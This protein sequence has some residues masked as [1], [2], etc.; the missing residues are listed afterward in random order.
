MRLIDLQRTF[1]D[2]R[3]A[4]DADE[5]DWREFLDAKGNQGKLAWS[6]LHTRPVSIVL[7]EAGIGK[8][9]EFKLEAARLRRNG[10]HA[11]LIPLNQLVGIESWVLA[12]GEYA[13]DFEKWRTGTDTGHFLFDAVDEARLTGPGALVK[14]LQVARHQLRGAP[15]RARILLSSRITDWAF[16]EVRSAVGD[17]L[18][19]PVEAALLAAQRAIAPADLSSSKD[20]PEP[21]QQGDDSDIEP[22]VVSL[23]PLSTV[24]ASRLAESF[25]LSDAQGFWAAIEDGNYRFM[26]TRPLDL[27]WLVDLWNERRALGT[28]QELL[29]HNVGNRLTE[30]N[31]S[32]HAAQATVEP[33]KLRRGAEALAA[34]TELSGCAY[35]STRQQPAV[36]NGIVS[37]LQMLT[38]WGPGEIERLLASALFDEATF[39]RVRFHHRTTRAYLAAWWVKRLIDSGVPLS[40]VTGLFTA[41]PFGTPVLIPGRRWAFCWLAA[42]DVRVREWVTRHFPEMVLFDGDPQAWDER[43][44]LLA[45][46]RYVQRLAEGFVPDWYNERSEFMRLARRLP[47]GVVARELAKP[48]SPWR[49]RSLML[50]LAFHGRLQDC[51]GTA[52]EIYRDLVAD[53]TDKR[54]ALLTVGAI[55]SA[56]QRGSIREDLLTGHIASNEL[57]AA[58]LLAIDWERLDVE[59]LAKIFAATHLEQRHRV[60]PMADAVLSGLLPKATATFAERLLAALLKAMRW[61]PVGDYTEELLEDEQTGESWLLDVLPNCLEALLRLLPLGTPAYPSV[62]VD[63]AVRVEALRNTAHV[64]ADVMGRIHDLVKPHAPLRWAI[65]LAIGRSEGHPYA[66]GSLTWG[67][68]CVVSFDASD[69]AELIRRANDTGDPEAAEIW[70]RVAVNLAFRTQRG[71][72][73]ATSLQTLCAGSQAAERTRFIADE[74][75]TRVLALR[76]H[77]R[78]NHKERERDAKRAA[79]FAA[80]RDM[81]MRDVEHIRSGEHVRALVHLVQFSYARGGRQHLD[82]I[83]YEIIREAYGVDV[84]DALAAG[85][86]VVWETIDVPDPANHPSSIPWV[87]ILAFAGLQTDLD[88]GLRLEAL[89]AADARRAARLAVWEFNA[90]PSWFEPMARIHLDVVAEALHPWILRD[91]AAANEAQSFHRALRMALQCSSATRSALLAP[92]ADAAALHSIKHTATLMQVMEALRKDG[93]LTDAAVADTCRR[94]IGTSIT[95]NGEVG[96]QNW[97]RFWFEADVVGAWRWFEEHVRAR[98]GAE[99]GNLAICLARATRRLKLVSETASG[100]SGIDTMVR[101]HAF[102]SKHLPA[103]GTPVAPEHAGTFGHVVSEVHQAIPKLLASR[104]GIAVHHALSR[105]AGVTKNADEKAWLDALQREHAAREASLVSLDAEALHAIGAGLTEAPQSESQLFAQAVAR[106]DE[107]RRGIEEGPFSE[108]NLFTVGMPEKF[109]QLWLASKLRDTPNRHFTVTREEEMDAEKR[110]DVQLGC[111]HGNACIEISMRPAITS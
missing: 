46:E 102:L 40:R 58:A 54:Q 10:R 86:K 2:Y 38:D 47:G 79:D 32:Y 31:E 16:D 59:E 33:Q 27:R 49:V 106:L 76:K 28:Y 109:L 77:R 78:G 25:G 90:P 43:T 1:S 24:E 71:R 20:L 19:R 13:G 55:G 96:E 18:C 66:V 5:T 91:A 100:D 7:G 70:F 30:V 84:A 21:D 42:I 88:R 111:K 9:C 89:T 110:T 98:S 103:P 73:R 12:L 93:R 57:R 23:D 51:A 29:E 105:I 35:V 107:I 44:A 63:A 97:L 50:Q 82:R 104:P 72:T 65:A 34:R 26:A 95:G 94:A 53:D 15:T 41:A 8:S 17:H 36:G 69:L 68:S 37:A 52:M 14:A 108:R 99:G 39:G 61:P 56:E 3:D 60:G 11:F 87:T 48:H 62:C 74:S 81:L 83:N 6:D 64:G 75:A 80:A 4:E 85:L 101:M 22:F 67:R 92:L 45:F